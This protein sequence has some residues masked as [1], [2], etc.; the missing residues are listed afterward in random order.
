MKRTALLV[1]SISSIL[2]S[3]GANASLLDLGGGLI[4]DD[5]LNVTWVQDANLCIALDNCALD[6]SFNGV[7]NWFDANSWAEDLD[8]G[9]FDDWRL[10]SVDINGDGTIVDCSTSSEVECRDNQLG[11]MYYY[12][13]TPPGDMPPTDIGTDLSGAPGPFVNVEFAFWSSTS[14]SASDAWS[15]WFSVFSGRQFGSLKEGGGFHA[16]AI[17]GPQAAAPEPSTLFLLGAM[18]STVIYVRRRSPRP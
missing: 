8:F 16:W 6:P 7:M 10:P 9:G 2:L 12:N 3:T 5:V 4:F 15:F 11:Y 14:I 1:G 18:A 13:L 17:R